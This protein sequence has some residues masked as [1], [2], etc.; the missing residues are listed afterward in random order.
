MVD[1]LHWAIGGAVGKRRQRQQPA[2]P[3]VDAAADD[4][5]GADHHRLDAGGRQHLFDAGLVQAVSRHRGCRVVLGLD[6]VSPAVD[7][8]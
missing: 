3:I 4:E 2:H 5:R 7:V 8:C 1:Y 6:R